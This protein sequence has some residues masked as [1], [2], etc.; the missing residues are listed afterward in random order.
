MKKVYE[1]YCRSQKRTKGLKEKADIMEGESVVKLTGILAVRWVS[2]KLCAVKALLNNWK[3]TILHLEEVSHSTKRDDGSNIGLFTFSILWLIPEGG[4]ETSQF[5]ETSTFNDVQTSLEYL[6]ITLTSLKESPGA[7]NLSNCDTFKYIEV[8]TMSTSSRSSQP[9]KD[10]EA[11]CQKLL[12]K[13]MITRR[14]TFLIVSV[15]FLMTSV[16]LL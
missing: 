4:I 8:I 14:N 5:R 12:L 16:H 3:C 9:H 1:F 2:S 10:G 13:S 15:S 7:R 11:F 6:I